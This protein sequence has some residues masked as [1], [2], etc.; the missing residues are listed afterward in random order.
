[1]SDLWL[2]KLKRAQ[3]HV[4]EIQR[5]ARRYADLHAYEVVGVR[6]P[7]KNHHVRIY[8]LHMTELPDPMLRVIL[9]E[10]INNL[11]SSLDNIFV[12][13]V[14]KRQR[15]EVAFPL[16]LEEAVEPIPNTIFWRPKH[17]EVGKRFKNSVQ[18]L[19]IKAQALIEKVQPYRTHATRH[20]HALGLL[21]RLD[22]ANKHRDGIVIGAGLADYHV[23]V[24]APGHKPHTSGRRH[25]VEDGAEICRF[26]LPA[27]VSQSEVEVEIRGTAVITVQIRVEG[28]NPPKHF[29]LKRLLWRS[30]TD[31]RWVIRRMEPF[32]RR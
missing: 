21:A 19:P 22:N 29:R 18:H 17:N 11:R 8:R 6:G 27:G 30:L 4:V 26:T 15:F 1:M 20:T 12:A 13:C 28:L 16:E 2:L 5:E 7:S 10:F 24:R 32:V 9:G 31:T 3:F 25:F 14:P 23:T